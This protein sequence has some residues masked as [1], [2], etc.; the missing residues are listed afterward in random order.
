MITPWGDKCYRKKC[1]R[2]S[3][4]RDQRVGGQLAVFY[5]VFR[6]SFIEMTIFRQRL[7]AGA[8][9]NR[10]GVWGGAGLLKLPP[11]EHM[12]SA[13]PLRRG[14]LVRGR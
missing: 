2:V 13:E 12:A 6:V 11:A 3:N 10:A 1:S 7:E 9:T 14:C 4:I 8:C 5:K